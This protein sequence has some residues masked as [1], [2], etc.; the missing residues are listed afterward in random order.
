[1]VSLEQC[2]RILEA[3][4]SKYTDEDVRLIRDYLYKQTS[5]HKMI[6]DNLNSVPDQP[7][8]GKYEHLKDRNA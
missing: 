4:G 3:D 7:L 1:M 8:P 2:K 5:I 6:F